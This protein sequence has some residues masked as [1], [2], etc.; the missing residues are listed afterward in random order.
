MCPS[1]MQSMPSASV[2]MG[3]DGGGDEGIIGGGGDEGI[4]CAGDG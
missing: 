2:E 1:D 3:G 4:V